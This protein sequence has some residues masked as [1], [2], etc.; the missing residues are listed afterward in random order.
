MKIMLEH[1]ETATP[2]LKKFFE[3]FDVVSDGGDLCVVVGGDGTFMRAAGKHDAP[4]LLIRDGAKG[5]VG[6]YSDVSVEDIGVIVEKLTSGQYQVETLANK[7][8]VKFN[9]RSSYVVNDAVIH[10]Q[11]GREISLQVNQI[12]NGRFERLTPKAIPGDGAIITGKI[13][14]TAY[15]MSAGGPIVRDPDVMCVTFIAPDSPLRNSI[16][17]ARGSA[18]EIE[19]EKSRGSLLNDGTRAAEVDEG[20][21][22]TATVS[23]QQLRVVTFSE[24]REDFSEKFGRV[25]R[26]KL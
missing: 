14:S 11:E 8:E 23:Q 16:I 10:A 21:V 6:W 26:G 18:I 1:R 4:I 13:G 20:D 2:Y 19:V 5:S 17:P 15:N 9:G 3:K 25:L 12:S 22:I 24:K 7:L